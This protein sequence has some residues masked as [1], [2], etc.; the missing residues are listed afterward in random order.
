MQLILPII[1]IGIA[2]VVTIINSPKIKEIK[3]ETIKPAITTTEI[4]V[5]TETPTPTEKVQE[6]PI[7]TSTQS[8][9][10]PQQL[11]QAD[12]TDLIYPGSNDKG[13][14][15]YESDDDPDKIT[16]WYKEKIKSMGMNVKT[17]VATKTNG[18]VL[19]KLAGA[20]SKTNISIEIEKEETESITKIKISQGSS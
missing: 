15:N 18:N 9:T 11:N 5:E 13:G 3:E 8:S 12:S 16:D 14:S 17:F 20:N 2:A 10:P 19:N 6:I 7:P 4:P 1:A